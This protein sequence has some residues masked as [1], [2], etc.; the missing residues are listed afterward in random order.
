MDILAPHPDMAKRIFKELEQKLDGLENNPY[1]YPVYYANP[2]YR[3]VNL[4]G[5]ALFYTIDEDM[6]MVYVYRI[7]YAKRDI[8]RLMGGQAVKRNEKA[9][10]SKDSGSNKETN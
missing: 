3:R 2:K 6:C 5:H 1:I 9:A 4:E 10:P 7:F 8:E